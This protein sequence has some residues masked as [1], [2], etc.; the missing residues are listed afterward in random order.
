[1]ATQKK[2]FWSYSA[3]ERGRNRVRV[4]EDPKTRSLLLE[5]SEPEPATGQARRKRVA[6]GHRD[7]QLAK[8]QCDQ[9]AA[10]LAAREPPRLTEPTVRDLIDIYVREVTPGKGESKAKHDRRCAELFIRFLGSRKAATLNVRDWNRF[11]TERRSGALRPAGSPPRPVGERVIAYDL[12][13]LLAVLNWAER[14]RHDRG[15]VLLEHNPL[16]G[17]PL[18]R[19]ES[20]MRPVLTEGQYRELSRIAAEVSGAFRLALALAHETGH[21]IGAIRQ[22]QWA[23]VDLDRKRIRWRAT[24]DKLGLDHTTPLTTE[25]AALLAQERSNQPAIGT[26]WVFPSPGDP[27]EP[28]SRHLMRDWWERA[29]RLAGLPDDQRLGWH[30]LRRKFATDLKRLPAKDL[31]ET[32]GWKRY[33]TVVTCY[34]QGDE[35]TQRSAL[36]ERSKRRVAVD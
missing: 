22:L 20:P 36:E 3:G 10:K 32:G 33:E 13:F 2:K 5:F 17:L 9:L 16:K 18:P 14:A 21:R 12:K 34:M 4:Y 8:S 1:M 35:E 31:C 26:A 30:S 25:A 15:T 28:C 27:T 7:K 24:N 29:A 23:D 11:I 19:T 6:V